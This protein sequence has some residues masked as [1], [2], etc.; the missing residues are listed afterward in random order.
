MGKFGTNTHHPSPLVEYDILPL[1]IGKEITTTYGVFYTQIFAKMS[2]LE[3]NYCG[4]RQPKVAAGRPIKN[5]LLGRELVQC[6]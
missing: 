3:I 4:F 5:Q 2:H 6:D 1:A